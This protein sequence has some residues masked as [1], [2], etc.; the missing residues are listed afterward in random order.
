MPFDP[1]DCRPNEA[2]G[3]DFDYVEVVQNRRR[4]HGH[5]EGV[6][7]VISEAAPSKKGLAKRLP[8]DG[9]VG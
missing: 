2:R 6:P 4:W 9:C 7:P 1:I 5:N 8:K 3:D